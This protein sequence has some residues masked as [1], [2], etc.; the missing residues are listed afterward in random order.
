MKRKHWFETLAERAAKASGS[1]QAFILICPVTLL[2]LGSGPVFHWSD[3]W[4][5]VI[6]SVTNIVSMLMVFLIQNSQNRNSSAVQLKLDELLRA[7]REAKNAFINI[8]ELTEEDLC[9]IKER[10]ADLAKTARQARQ[11]GGK[12]T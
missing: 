12:P 7:G 1:S 2:W 9:R 6:N 8:E 11:E 5:L 3:T 4:Q 10:Y